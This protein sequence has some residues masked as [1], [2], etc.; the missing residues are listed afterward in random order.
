LGAAADWFAPPAVWL[1]PAG[2]GEPEGEADWLEPE[3]E[4]EGEPVW[5][6]PEPEGEPVWLEP[7]PEGEPVWLLVAPEP[8]GEAVS[9]E[10][11]VPEAAAPPPA[12]PS[13]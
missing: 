3:G 8:P 5:L 6:E 1:E 4:P 11:L 13:V 2:A 9:L 7:E 10:A 12:E